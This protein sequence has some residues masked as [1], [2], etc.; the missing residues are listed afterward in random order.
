MSA[1][2][3]VTIETAWNC[4]FSVF[5]VE[6]SCLEEVDTSGLITFITVFGH[7]LPVRKIVDE[8]GLLARSLSSEL[9]DGTRWLVGVFRAIVKYWFAFA[10]EYRIVVGSA[11]RIHVLIP[12]S[13][14]SC[15]V[16]QQP[17]Q[18]TALHFAF[19]DTWLATTRIGKAAFTGDIAFCGETEVSLCFVNDA[20]ADTSGIITLDSILI[21]K[22]IAHKGI[23][24]HLAHQT[25]H[26]G[27][28]DATV[29]GI[30]V[31]HLPSCLFIAI[32]TEHTGNGSTARTLIVSL[33]GDLSDTQVVDR[34]RHLAEDT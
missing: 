27:T 13:G 20:A 14:K 26:I 22:A 25:A 9:K 24:C 4:K 1:T 33:D 34:S 3:V 16:V 21:S 15:L 10:V 19:A 7:K 29:G 12:D 8:E 28:C 5:Q 30:A 31:T 11:F 6:V 18:L 23:V 2:V 17:C 32:S